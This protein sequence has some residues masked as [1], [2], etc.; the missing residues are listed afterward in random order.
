MIGTVDWFDNKRGFGMCHTETEKIWLNYRHVLGIGN[1]HI[2]TYKDRTTIISFDSFTYNL[3]KKY[4]KN[5][6]VLKTIKKQGK[7]NEN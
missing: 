2:P 7:E 4:A 6:F 1:K 5:V 3:E